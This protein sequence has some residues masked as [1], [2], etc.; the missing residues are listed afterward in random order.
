[1]YI[2]YFLNICTDKKRNFVLGLIMSEEES[3]LSVQDITVFFDYDDPNPDNISFSN[4][5][6]IRLSSYSHVLDLKREIFKLLGYSI[7]SINL[8]F[9]NTNGQLFDTD[10]ISIISSPIHVIIKEAKQSTDDNY[11]YTNNT[12]EQSSDEEEE[13]E[14]DE[15]EDSFK[16]VHIDKNM[17]LSLKNDNTKAQYL[18][19]KISPYNTI[20]QYSN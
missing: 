20:N 9:I 3:S 7:S 1:M 19:H 11:N 2:Y 10:P 14:S 17:E 18:F 15:Y 12:I 5:I 8:F 4:K 13:N 6:T 16:C